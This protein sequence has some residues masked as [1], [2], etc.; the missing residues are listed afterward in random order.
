[1][2]SY[3]EIFLLVWALAATVAAVRYH[4]M[5]DH[6]M[7]MGVTLIQDPAMYAEIRAR[8]EAR[9]EAAGGARNDD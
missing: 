4:H 6:A 8:V 2:I 3:S 5:F 9:V 7:R 1:L